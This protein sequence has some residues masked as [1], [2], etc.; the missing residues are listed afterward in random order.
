METSNRR[1]V[2]FAAPRCKNTTELLSN[3]STLPTFRHVLCIRIV[4]TMSKKEMKKA[5][6]I[7]RCGF[8]IR[9]PA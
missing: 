7:S 5:A 2:N 8:K 9:L 3:M 6:T 1:K 4:N